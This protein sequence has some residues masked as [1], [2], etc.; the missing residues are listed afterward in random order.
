MTGHEHKWRTTTHL[1][2]CHFYTTIY[3]CTR[4]RATVTKTIER[5][6]KH[7][8][9]SGIWMERQWRE[10]RRDERGRFITPTWEEVVCARCDE[11][12]AGAPVR[13]DLVVV[14]KD[15]EIEREEHTEHEQREPEEAA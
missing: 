9:M 15:G 3:A 14:S 12:W 8:P 4:C 7:D 10:R 2:A 6:P 1:D 11:L 13:V 5:D